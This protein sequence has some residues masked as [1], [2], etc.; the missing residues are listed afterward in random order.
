[1][2]L[3]TRSKHL[4]TPQHHH[5]HTSAFQRLP[6]VGRRS[7]RTLSAHPL[8]QNA[9]A[10][11]YMGIDFGTSGARVT[12]IDGRLKHES[13]PCCMA[14]PQGMYIRQLQQPGF[15]AALCPF[16]LALFANYYQQLLW[17]TKSLLI[18]Y[19][20]KTEST[21]LLSPSSSQCFGQNMPR[22]LCSCIR[23]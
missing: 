21:T 12:V 11:Y 6:L 14:R 20:D 1:M 22:S 4:N 10:M 5:A 13:I 7:C 2:L 17:P 15:Y 3:H 16:L 9:G 8:V 23:S 19:H 18:S